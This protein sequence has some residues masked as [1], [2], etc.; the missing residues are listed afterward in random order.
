MYPSLLAPHVCI[1]LGLCSMQYASRCSE[2]FVAADSGP[3]HA[4][5]FDQEYVPTR[6]ERAYASRCVVFCI[7]LAL[8]YAQL[9]LVLGDVDERGM[10]AWSWACWLASKGAG[11][12]WQVLG[13]RQTGGRTRVHRG[14]TSGRRSVCTPTCECV[15]WS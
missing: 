4:A 8:W 9:Y 3:A 12:W 1:R 11:V 10:R 13:G 5:S 15:S 14:R 2:W 7:Q 6:R